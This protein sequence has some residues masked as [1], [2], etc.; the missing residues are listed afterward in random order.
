MMVAALVPL[1]DT[2]A[3]PDGKLIAVLGDSSECLVA[4][5]QSG[6]VRAS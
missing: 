5:A 1:Q 3:S 4:D 6:K 2:S